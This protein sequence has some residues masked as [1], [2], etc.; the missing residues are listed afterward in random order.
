MTKIDNRSILKWNSVNQLVNLSSKFVISVILQRILQPADFGVIANVLV[1]ASIT[2]IFIDSGFQSSIIQAKEIPPK[3]LSTIFYLNI[4]IGAACTILLFAGSHFIGVFYDSP[5]LSS[6]A[7]LI[8]F[9]YLLQSFVLVQRAILIKNHLFKT[10][11]IVDIS[12]NII[13]G[14]IAVVMALNGYNVWSIAVMYVAQILISNCLIWM[15]T[16]WWPRL[17]F[18]LQSVR[19]LW[20]YGSKVLL[21]GFV[22]FANNRVDLL[23]T[24]KFFNSSQQGLY[25][26]GKDYGSLPSGII[27]G[28][29]SKSYFPIFSRLQDDKAQLKD[30]YFKALASMSFI[31]GL[32]F[33]LLFL[34]ARDAVLIVL[35]E[36]WI[37]MVPVLQ[38]FIVLSSFQVFNS[39]NINYL[40]GIGRSRTNLTVFSIIGPIRVLSVI[41]YF[42]IASDPRLVVVSAILTCFSFLET[43]MS[44][45]FISRIQGY[46]ARSQYLT[47]YSDMLIGWG[48]A[49]L[50]F[51]V[52]DV[53]FDLK[54]SSFAQITLYS[55]FYLVIYLGMCYKLKN[56][57][58]YAWI[59]RISFVR[60]RVKN[61]NHTKPV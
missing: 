39:V 19:S 23:M 16:N 29:I 46:S 47:S 42:L 51:M 55:V 57:F 58:L 60:S 26:R 50:L 18:D 20:K 25:S 34:C 38:L 59:A 45:F 37:G 32:L 15:K 61:A 14:I 56:P 53:I 49:F 40:A 2:E 10:I 36:K 52:G 8:S 44:F 7:K 28:I 43:S 48:I 22:V 6:V 41:T 21:S 54:M 5:L 1:F 13:A 33:P 31:G 12:S 30:N 9:T 17:E 11:A 3:A 35:K 27:I 24:G 4:G